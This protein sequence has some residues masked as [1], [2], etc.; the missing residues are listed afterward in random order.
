MHYGGKS[1][2]FNLCEFST[3]NL[4]SCFRF[5]LIFSI[6][7]YFFSILFFIIL[8][9]CFSILWDLMRG[10]SSSLSLSSVFLGVNPTAQTATGIIIISMFYIYLSSLTWSGYL[11]CISSIW[12]SFIPDLEDGK[13]HPAISYV[14]EINFV[15]CLL[16]GIK[17]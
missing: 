4:T 7:F 16:V 13:I 3:P 17:W 2:F 12:F 15:S 1:L 6:L 8:F 10:S 11:Y 14:L 9:Y 5:F